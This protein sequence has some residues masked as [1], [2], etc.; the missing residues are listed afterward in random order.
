ML[1]LEQDATITIPLRS[2]AQRTLYVDPEAQITLSLP[3]AE[4]T[5]R[6]DPDASVTIDVE[7]CEE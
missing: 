7:G 6:I 4:H 5:L 2:D 3:Y 1:Q